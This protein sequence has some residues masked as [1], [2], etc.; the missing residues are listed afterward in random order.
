VPTIPWLASVLS[1][2]SLAL[3]IK[4]AVLNSALVRASQLGN[5]DTLEWLL[6]HAAT[7]VNPDSTDS[8]GLPAIVL[9]TSLRHG[10]CVR[11]LVEAGAQIDARDPAGWT[12]LHWATQ[13]SDFPLAAYLLNHRASLDVRSHKGLRPIDLVRKGPAGDAMREI[14]SYAEERLQVEANGVESPALNARAKGKAKAVE[15]EATRETRRRHELARDCA[16]HL[17]LDMA[18]LGFT[19]G[20]A[21]PS[22]RNKRSS[23]GPASPKTSTV[24]D[25]FL[26]DACRLDQMMVRRTALL[27][28]SR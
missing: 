8:D 4:D 5:G 2:S 16:Q 13:G 26:W 21:G 20:H 17:E 19:E 3:D 18:Q 23:L 11:I 6:Q 7:Y 25:D 24:D 1:A 28:G 12:A 22:R 27:L 9:A 15:D 14:L 10:D